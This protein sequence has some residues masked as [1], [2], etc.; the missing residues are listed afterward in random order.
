MLPCTVQL[1]IA[2]FH[3]FQCPFAL[4]V[5][6][7]RD[8]VFGTQVGEDNV[9]HA[10]PPY[11]LQKRRGFAVGCV[12]GA[13][14]H[15]LFQGPGVLALHQH[16]LVMVGLHH[17]CVAPDGVLFDQAGV[18]ARIGHIA[19]VTVLQGTDAKTHRIGGIVGNTENL[20][21]RVT[22]GKGRAVVQ[23]DKLVKIAHGVYGALTRELGGVH[24]NAE[25]A[26][27]DPRAADVVGMFV[28]KQNGV[29]GVFVNADGVQPLNQGFAV[30]PRVNQKARLRRLYQGRV[31][32]GTAGKNR[33]AHLA[34]GARPQGAR[35]CTHTYC[36]SFWMDIGT[37]GWIV[38][39][40]CL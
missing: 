27:K 26:G 28:G 40:A 13:G 16:D 5:G 15:P 24:R 18:N 1:G 4:L 31:P 36:G 30:E 33:Q 12:A 14:A 21:T 29:N 2:R 23:G 32:L 39:M 9:L 19:Q 7:G 22:K 6:Q 3:A 8:I 37:L 17:Q 11:L 25:T 20:H 10:I 35:C 38:L 34:P